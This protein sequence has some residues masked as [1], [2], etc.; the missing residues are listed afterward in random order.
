MGRTPPVVIHSLAIESSSP[1]S[2]YYYFHHHHHILFIIPLHPFCVHVVQQGRILLTPLNHHQPAVTIN[3]MYLQYNYKVGTQLGTL[4]EVMIFY[5]KLVFIA[6]F[7]SE[8]VNELFSYNQHILG[9]GQRVEWV[10]H[11]SFYTPPTRECSANEKVKV[12]MNILCFEN[13]QI[14]YLIAHPSRDRYHRIINWNN[15]DFQ[16]LLDY[17]LNLF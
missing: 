9:G 14:A 16:E 6:N 17:I 1:W 13:V 15:C 12:L 10:R 7:I 11:L 2:C 4:G 5:L 3:L 8:L